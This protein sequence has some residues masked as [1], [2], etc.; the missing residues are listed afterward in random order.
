MRR[1][2]RFNVASALGIGVQ[3]GVLWILM[4]GLHV[5]YGA[6][7]GVAVLAAVGHNFVWH[8][9]WTWGDRAIPL[10]RVPAALARFLAANGA[11]SLVGNVVLMAVL[12]RGAGL[13]AIPAN[14]L[15]IAVCGLV[16]Y[17]LGDV[18]VFTRPYSARSAVSGSTREARHAGTAPASTPTTS[19]TA[20]ALANVTGS[21]GERS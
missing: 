5:G 12:V 4:R 16:N 18:I 8:W 9:R 11:V 3:L 13:P 1:F 15:A 20:A 19:N 21:C 6:A 14:V 7:T 10:G 2:L 17:W